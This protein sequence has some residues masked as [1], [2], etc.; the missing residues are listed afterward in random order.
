MFHVFLEQLKSGMATH[1]ESE[2]LGSNPNPQW[3]TGTMFH[4]NYVGCENVLHF[5]YNLSQQFFC[6]R[7]CKVCDL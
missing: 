4:K 1:E 6:T 2:W 5:F 3:G 7:C